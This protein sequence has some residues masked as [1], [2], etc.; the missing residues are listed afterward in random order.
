[1]TCSALEKATQSHAARNTALPDGWGVS[2]IGDIAVVTDYVANG[3]FASL[4]ENVKYLKE[5][6]YAVLIRTTD[7]NKGWNGDYVYMDKHAYEF[8]AKSVV[9]PGDIVV[10]NVGEPGQVFRAPDLKMP[11]TLGPNSILLKPIGD[12]IEKGFLENFLK[13]PY[14][15]QLIHGITSATTQRKFNKTEFRRLKIPIAPSAEQKRIVEKVEELLARNNAA[16][17]RLAKVP[18]ILKRLRQSVLAAACSGRLTADWREK[19]RDLESA[20]TLLENIQERRLQQANT[21]SQRQKINEIYS[22]QKEGDSHS[23]P[24]NWRYLALDKLCESFQYGTSKKSEPSGK[25]AVLR[26]GNIQDGEIDW[27]DL[28]YT[29]DDEEI[30]KYKLNPRDVLFNRTNS[31]E[32]VGKTAIYR[33]DRPAIFAGYLIKIH[34]FKELD[35]RYLNFCLN[36]IYAKGFCLKAKTDGVSQSNIN[37]QKLGKFEV[38]FCPLEEQLE[39]VRRV[40]AMFK[41]ADVIEKR[42]SAAT[43]RAEKLTQAILVKAFRGELVSTEAEL[44]R[45][46]GRSYETAS[47]LLARIKSEKDAKQT[48]QKARR[49]RG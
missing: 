17:D 40:E 22:Y 39:I 35:S 24:E 33:G 9:K 6:G 48:S 28:V 10:S 11:M 49:N 25:V 14:G 31:P 5:P 4:R 13:S 46:D 7:H 15:Q 37:A 30:E 34:N 38:P 19:N 18:L 29:S 1:V 42:V 3:S 32:L 27:S 2:Q 16:R 43:M 12:Q 8:L 20:E 23:L 36:M 21:P 47:E 44:A 45:R 26:M 41:L